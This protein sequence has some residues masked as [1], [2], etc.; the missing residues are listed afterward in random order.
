VRAVWVLARAQ[1][2]G[3]RPALE[4]RQPLVARVQDVVRD[5]PGAQVGAGLADVVLVECLVGDRDLAAQH[6]AQRRRGGASLQPGQRRSRLVVLL[7]PCEQ[8]R[9]PG[10][11]MRVTLCAQLRERGVKRAARAALLAP[12]ASLGA[13]VAA[14]LD[15]AGAGAGGADG[16]AVD[17]CRGPA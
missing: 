9:E 17:P 8:R 16:R 7:E 10:D 12:V 14:L 5:E 6:C 13:A 15:R 1:E 2:R 4:A 11:G 3:V